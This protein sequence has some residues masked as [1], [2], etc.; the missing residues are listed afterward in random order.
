MEEEVVNKKE[1]KGLKKQYH[2]LKFDYFRHKNEIRDAKKKELADL[3]EEYIYNRLLVEKPL[4]AE[5][6]RLRMQKRKEHRLKNEAPRRK[7]LEE[8]G[9]AVTHGVGA[10]LGIFFLV[11]M[12]N[13]A[14]NPM[15]MT[16]AVVYGTCFILQML[17][18]CLYHS[19][20]GGTR[21][22]RIFRRFDYCSIY[23]Q[24]GGSFAPLFLIYMANK[25]WGI[26]WAWTL[27]ISQWAIILIGVTFN[28]VFGPGRI[29]ILNYTL[30]FAVGWSGLIFVPTWF[31]LDYQLALWII[32]GGVIYTLGMIPFG[33]FRH[34]SVTHFIWHIV[35]LVGAVLMWCGMYL[36]VF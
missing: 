31:R 32:S 24:L 26:E 1:Y 14:N 23:L 12:I 3:K 5:K 36:H 20:R 11:L 13:K 21:V 7:V 4:K 28:A 25:M 30:L 15:A 33:V 18:S 8:I 9:N 17:F 19:F 27:F 10:A 16:A 2:Q 22:K 35:V 6:Y 34:R 29:R